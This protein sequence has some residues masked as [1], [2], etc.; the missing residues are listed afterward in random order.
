MQ[1]VTTL[2]A[3]QPIAITIGNFDGVHKGHQRLMHEL[4]KTAQEL[5]CTPVLVTFS[6]HTLMI[7]RPDID[8]RY[9]T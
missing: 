5:N 6:P 7:V 8:V 1:Y 9:L 2:T 4:R 3:N